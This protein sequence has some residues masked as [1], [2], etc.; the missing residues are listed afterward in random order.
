MIYKG[1]SIRIKV[2]DKCKNLLI[3][4]SFKN[5]YILSNQNIVNYEIDNPTK[6]MP[7]DLKKIYNE[8]RAIYKLSPTGAA[9]LLRSILE[10]SLIK[11]FPILNDQKYYTLTAKLQ[12]QEVINIIGNYNS[13][14]D[15]NSN[16]CLTLIKEIADKSV[17]SSNINIKK[18]NKYINKLFIWINEIV[19]K[20]FIEYEKI[21]KEI[22]K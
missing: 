9:L 17:H 22:I 7:N 21:K 12:Y 15:S 2:C 18:L 10:K 4:E 8:A 20:L 14:N 16:K 19:E 13:K 1:V 5:K 3:Y 6:Y 11:K